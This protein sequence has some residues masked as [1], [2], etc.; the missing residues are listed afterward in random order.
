MDPRLERYQR[1]QK[2]RGARERD[3][4]IGSSIKAFAKEQTRLSRALGEIADVFERTVPAEIASFCTLVGLKAGT[5][6]V[7]LTSD[8]ARFE[9]DRFLRQGGEAALK[10]QSSAANVRITKVRVV[11]RHDRS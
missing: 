11:M 4:E 2:W 3:V 10:D 9:L 5:L 1:M 7:E 6:T 8:S